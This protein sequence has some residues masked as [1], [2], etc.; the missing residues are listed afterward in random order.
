MP[1]KWVLPPPQGD[2]GRAWCLHKH[3]VVPESPP[4][5]PVA[6]VY[7]ISDWGYPS[8]AL[9]WG[10]QPSALGNR[11]HWALDTSLLQEP[12]EWSTLGPRPLVQAEHCSP[13]PLMS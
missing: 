1:K 2:E 9:S 8:V 5:P 11:V 6:L 3:V 4:T 7:I 10:P 12:E 13:S